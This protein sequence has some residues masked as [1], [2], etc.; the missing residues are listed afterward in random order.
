MIKVFV[1]YI[2]RTAY[3]PFK[4]I[5]MSDSL[6][7]K[8]DS[9]SFIMEIQQFAIQPPRS[10]QV[11]EVR[12]Y[13]ATVAEANDYIQN[14]VYDS[15]FDFFHDDEVDLWYSVEFKGIIQTVT[16]RWVGP[17]QWLAYE[18]T[19]CDFTRQFDRHLVNE[20]YPQ[21]QWAGDIVRDII[22]TYTT[23]FSDLYVE[24]G[25]KVPE[26]IFDF[27]EP[28]ACIQEVAEYIG[29]QWYVDF[30]KNVHFFWREDKN[31]PLAI[32]RGNIYDIDTEF[33]YAYNLELTED[34]S[35]LKNK[36]LVKNANFKGVYTNEDFVSAQTKFY[37]MFYKP[38]PIT[39]VAST[40]L[41]RAQYF[42]IEIYDDDGAGHLTLDTERPITTILLDEVEGKVGDGT[43][44]YN[45]VYINFGTGIAN[46]GI[47]FPDNFPLEAGKVARVRYY[48]IEAVPILEQDQNSI[49]SMKNKEGG[50]STG[51]Y[52]YS[53][54]GSS[55]YTETGEEVTAAVDRVLLR[56][57]NPL[58][59]GTFQSRL[60]GWQAGQVFRLYSI[61]WGETSWLPIDEMVWV[62]D[63]TKTIL[64]DDMI[65]YTVSF[66]SSPFGD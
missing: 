32:S 40:Q 26:M 27:S 43:G 52:E 56:Y 38:Y 5:S 7:I 23:G 33:T 28:S 55:V 6:S 9:L 14:G 37:K 58:W 63:V 59:T 66:S 21:G 15:M 10:S 11:V 51:I 4:S 22:T 1:N 25:F 36:I 57:K 20:T 45:T 34:T 31:S 54:D 13:F 41:S 39:D 64:K 62:R 44:D 46:C 17:P 16:R 2:D 50:D 65:E 61:R 3:I 24:R 47:R 53:F 8:S 18:C 30:N 49:D 29:Y 35:Q 12:Y 42:T 19:C 48:K 60:R